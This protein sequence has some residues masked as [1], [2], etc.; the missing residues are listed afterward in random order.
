MLS[1]L[2]IGSA[3][4]SDSAGTSTFQMEGLEQPIRE[5]QLTEM[6]DDVGRF[7]LKNLI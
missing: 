7:V 5:R 2:H 4:S 6:F 1:D 3:L